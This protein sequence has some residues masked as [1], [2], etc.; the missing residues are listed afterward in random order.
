MFGFELSE[1]QRMIKDAL[2]QFAADVIRPAAPEYD[3]KEEMPWPIMKQAQVMG[4]G[5][6]QSFGLSKK[7]GKDG[8]SAA[9]SE[10]MGSGGWNLLA[11]LATEELSWGCA[12]I[13][14]AIN[15][16]GLAATPVAKMGT[17]EQKEM[18]IDAMTGDD[19]NG[20]PKIAAMAITEPK[21]GSDISMIR[22]SAKKDGDHYILNGQK[23]FITNGHSA[24]I[25]IIWATV[26]PQA[27]RAGH[28]AFLIPRGT[29]GLVP[30]AKDKKL[31]IRASETAPVY[32]EDCRVPAKWILGDTGQ[33]FS[34]AKKMFDATRPVV[35]SMAL[36]IA[37]A[38]LEYTVDYTKEREQFGC[39]LAGK[40]HIAF[41]LAEMAT[42][43]E[44]CRMLI[45]KAAW[46]ADKQIPNVKE[47]SMAK[48]LAAQVAMD[49]TVKAVQI[50]GGYGFL[51]D[52]PVEKWMR[53]AKIFDIFEGTGEIQRAIVAK[54]LTGIR[55]L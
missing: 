19:E 40:Q 7:N 27:G 48:Y 46:M 6:P 43:V 17:P 3:E 31:G 8:G 38:A 33:G 50:L 12:G 37:R 35:A 10:I 23:Q 15:G 29:P 26:D 25:F 55:V 24:S 42:A 51:R 54:E 39:A 44:S 4:M 13:T 14:N 32:L 41:T 16:S 2:H 9:M 18:F 34:G 5:T 49:V 20:H 47:A 21:A 28:R 30:G 52:Y 53:D 22:T 36:G 1:T 45:W 11:V